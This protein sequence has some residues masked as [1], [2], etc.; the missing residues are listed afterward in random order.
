MKISILGSSACL[1]SDICYIRGFQQQG[2]ELQYFFRMSGMINPLFKLHKKYPI[3]I[4]PATEVEE[5]QIYKDYVDLQ[6][7]YLISAQGLKFRSPRLLLLYIKV[8][9]MIMK[10]N[11]DVV[12][13]TWPWTRTPAITYLLPKKKSMLVHDPLPHS[14]HDDVIQEKYRKFGFKKADKLILL[15]DK[16]TEEFCKKYN[17]ASSKIGFTQLC[18]FDYLDYVPYIPPN[19]TKK[20]LLFFGQI[21]S[22]KGL[23]IL[24]EAM[25]Q[26]HL[27]HPEWKLIVAGGGKMYFDTSE[28]ANLD[29]IEFR[30][31]FIDIPE[32]VGL[33][34]HCEF[35][36]AP[37][38]D[39]TQ[40]GILNNALSLNKPMIVT[41]VGNFT[42]LVKDGVTGYVVPPCDVKSL[43]SAI[44]KMIEN[45]N[46]RRKMS[47]SI[48]KE[49]RDTIK[50]NIITENLLNEIKQLVD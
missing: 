34:K 46:L 24:L 45:P 43:A 27:V 17:V 39:A 32:L 22:Y 40:S 7:I 3:G 1:D 14:S 23:D 35:A 31:R 42:D 5:M 15:N 41:D 38:R 12:H 9:R 37:Y 47:E 50:N 19:E 49:W 44:N 20:Y 29:Y 8:M 28:Y 21:A 18:V 30:N 4:I 6:S 16:T 33:I 11:P 36:V 13:H 26:V 48:I 2:V 10:F 25:K